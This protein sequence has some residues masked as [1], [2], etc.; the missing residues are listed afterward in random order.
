MEIS[1][2]TLFVLSSVDIWKIN[3]S[4]VQL[5]KLYK[6]NSARVFLAVPWMC[7]MNASLWLSSYVLPLNSTAATTTK[8]FYANT[9]TLLA[10][11]QLPPS[12]PIPPPCC[13]PHHF[14]LQCQYHH[15]AAAPNTST[16]NANTTTLL[17]PLP[18]PPSTPIP[19]PK[20]RPLPKKSID[21]SMFCMVSLDLV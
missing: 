3:E 14:H 8:T 17:P 1:V 2:S 7:V 11:L 5:L 19:P 9:T 20:I 13:C 4:Y 18:L 12:T 21:P 6:N 10:P 16:I 15:P